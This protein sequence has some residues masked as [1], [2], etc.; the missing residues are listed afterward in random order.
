MK[1]CTMYF[2]GT[3][4]SSIDE[5]GFKIDQSGSVW[6]TPVLN[7]LSTLRDL[8]ER[9]QY[10][11]MGG[12]FINEVREPK[13][14][15]CYRDYYALKAHFFIFRIKRGMAQIVVTPDRRIAAT[16]I[17]EAFGTNRHNLLT[18][19]TIAVPDKGGWFKLLFG[20]GS[21]YTS[22]F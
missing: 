13:A 5:E 20:S 7:Q 15:V 14:F 9:H 22:H 17:E 21:V 1:S 12:F 16:K 8:K 2:S 3:V 10:H 4:S 18:D 6:R 11:A 19:M